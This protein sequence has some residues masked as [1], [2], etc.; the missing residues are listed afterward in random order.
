MSF[1][2]SDIVRNE[3]LEINSLQQRVY[4][5]V[6]EYPSMSKERKMEHIEVLQELL[7]KQK[8]LYVRL[9]L[10]DDPEAKEMKERIVDSAKMMGLQEGMDISY[11]FGNMEK[12]LETM[13]EEIDKQS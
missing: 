1:F 6:F 2:D 7:E 4:D 5:N 13:K 9:S 12:L 10:S 11:M 3:M 8:V